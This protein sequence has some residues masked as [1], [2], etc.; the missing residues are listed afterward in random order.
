MGKVEYLVVF[1]FYDFAHNLEP[2][3]S[4]FC[5]LVFWSIEPIVCLKFVQGKELF[6]TL[7]QTVA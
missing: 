2:P 1:P 4:R 3:W 7:L 5:I 6:D